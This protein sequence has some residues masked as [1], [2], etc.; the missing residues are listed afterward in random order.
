MRVKYLVI[1]RSPV[2]IAVSA[3]HF[4][5]PTGLASPQ[6]VKAFFRERLPTIAAWQVI[7]GRRVRRWRKTY[8][9]LTTMFLACVVVT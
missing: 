1:L 4:F 7:R 5:S 9:L 3:S 6:Q 8:F 2:R